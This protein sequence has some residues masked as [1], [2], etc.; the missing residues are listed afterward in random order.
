MRSVSP[1]GDGELEPSNCLTTALNR[2]SGMAASQD[3]LPEQQA[4]PSEM[5]P[6]SQAWH[7]LSIWS[8]EPLGPH[9]SGG[10]GWDCAVTEL[11]TRTSQPSLTASPTC[12]QGLQD[13]VREGAVLQF[14]TSCSQGTTGPVFHLIASNNQPMYKHTPQMHIHIIER[15][16]HPELY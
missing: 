12:C 10:L 9:N 6:Q 4:K 5:G 16:F 15:Q 2:G 3:H 7:L 8:P 13:L 1:A 11:S 14:L